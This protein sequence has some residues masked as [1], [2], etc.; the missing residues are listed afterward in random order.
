VAWTTKFRYQVPG[1]DVGQRCRELLRE[2]A[3]SEEEMIYAGSINR[4]HVHSA[5]QYPIPAVGIPGGAVSGRE[6]LAPIIVGVQG[7]TE[8]ILGPASMGQGLLGSFDTV[9]A[10]FLVSNWRLTACSQ[11]D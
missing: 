9:L 1:G 5:D 7:I 2:I 8:A 11:H 10:P 6:E 4:D 3:M